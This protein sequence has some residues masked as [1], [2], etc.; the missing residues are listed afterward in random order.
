MGMFKLFLEWLL[1][2]GSFFK[3]HDTQI[4]H[5]WNASFLT[6][7]A[8]RNGR[9]MTQHNHNSHVIMSTS[10]S[11]VLTSYS[12]P[13]LSESLSEVILYKCPKCGSIY[14]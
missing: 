11:G 4:G 14:L 2:E 3:K 6:L 1:A 9:F 7:D 12:S 5:N 8:S 13:I 10:Q